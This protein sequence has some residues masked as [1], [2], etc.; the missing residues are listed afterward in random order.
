MASRVVHV[1]VMQVHGVDHDTLPSLACEGEHCKAMRQLRHV[2]CREQGE[3]DEG[4]SGR[5]VHGPCR[6]KTA[7][8]TWWAKTL[9]VAPRG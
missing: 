4:S 8:V 2:C 6:P 9:H 1:M 5:A 7:E 3:Q